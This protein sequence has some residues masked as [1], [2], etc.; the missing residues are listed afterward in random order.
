MATPR[1]KETKVVSTPPADMLE[2]DDAKALDVEKDEDE[3][4]MKFEDTPRLAM[5]KRSR[6]SRAKEMGVEIVGDASGDKVD[7]SAA[8]F[9]ETP[10]DE[11]TETKL[12]ETPGEEEVPAHVATLADTDLVEIKV[13]GETKKMSWAEAKKSLQLGAATEETLARA[14]A[15][16]EAA[17]SE[18]AAARAA[19]TVHT[20]EPVKA[21][22]PTAA[23]KAT[24]A[25]QAAKLAKKEAHEKY[26]QAVRYG[27]DEEI[28][29]AT[30]DL[31]AAD[32][33]Y[34]EARDAMV[35]KPAEV[36]PEE[37]VQKISE[38]NESINS[39]RQTQ[40]FLDK[41]AGDQKD[42]VFRAL[43][44]TRVRNEMF[45]DLTKLANNAHDKA[46]LEDNLR[47]LTDREIGAHHF[48]ARSRGLVRTLDK[49]FTS[50]GEQ[51]REELKRRSTPATTVVDARAERESKKQNTSSPPKAAAGRVPEPE[52]EKPKTAKDIM[53]ETKARRGK[54]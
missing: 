23:E 50:A 24:A 29:K 15:D 8:D 43:H 1:N 37:V 48:K 7:T 53:A 38:Q 36:D 46:E 12:E 44:A 5:M 4:S 35:A 42:E 39:K 13:N 49:V 14:K 3:G 10:A 16:K 26:T 45:S 22:E 41:F 51:A 47:K 25:L 2:Q 6:E 32:D 30:N 9:K 33:K 40:E 54:A 52:A 20:I 18:L 11:T 17:A 28:A 21:A 27:T 34:D 19:R 31:T